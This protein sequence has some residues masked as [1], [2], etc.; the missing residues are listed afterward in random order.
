MT[1][2]AKNILLFILYNTLVAILLYI[3]V[4]WGDEWQVV[5][6]VN[7]VKNFSEFI[8]RIQQEGHP[9]LWFGLVKLAWLIYP[10]ANAVKI[11]HW[12]ITAFTSWYLIFRMKVDFKYKAL[13]LFS[14]F[15][16]F[17]YAAICRNY[18]IVV[19][20]ALIA[21]NNIE[22]KNP[23]ALWAFCFGIGGMCFSHVYGIMMAGGLV[24]YLFYEK[25]F[26]VFTL[27][28]VRR[29]NIALVAFI[30]CTLVAAYT[31]YPQG[32]NTLLPDDHF[33]IF[34]LI[35]Y[36]PRGFAILWNA[37]VNIP[38][39]N[40]NFR[41]ENIIDY[42]YEAVYSHFNPH[43]D[44]LGR[45]YIV[46]G[47]CVKS[48]LVLPV[49][50]LVFKDLRQ[51]RRLFLTLLITYIVIYIFQTEFYRASLRHAGFSYVFLFLVVCLSGQLRLRF[52]PWL[53]ALQVIPLTVAV[54]CSFTH[55][56]SNG[57]AVSDYICS[58]HY[59]NPIVETNS[60]VAASSLAGY[61]AKPFYIHGELQENWYYKWDQNNV[62]DS[63][64][65][66]TLPKELN[67]IKQIETQSGNRPAFVVLDFDP[68]KRDSAAFNSYKEKYHFCLR[69]FEGAITGE[70]FYV[71]TL[72][73]F[74]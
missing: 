15:M 53:L 44:S 33:Q 4:L 6:I 50:Y 43:F 29:Y 27:F 37:L 28:S 16:G 52:I 74:E 35:L 67:R 2:L 41:G 70:D 30:C 54:C 9:P 13:F 68:E 46:G 56:F 64:F 32:H 11:L 36:L 23:R 45:T 60:P 49:L 59:D 39:F 25:L 18:G 34:K 57:K 3:H 62:T 8:Y 22:L 48:I 40:Y 42:F 12:C 21:V 55:P 14:Y 51:S 31:I 58:F 71:V 63:L 1:A 20:F 65:L 47:Y 26:H 17:E 61:Y 38:V 7:G 73:K 24:F 66:T 69:K 72:G 10:S 5:E 19:L